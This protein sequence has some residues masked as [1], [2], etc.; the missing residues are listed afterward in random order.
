[1]LCLSYQEDIE[2]ST[3][4][5]SASSSTHVGSWRVLCSMS[6]LVAMLED[7]VEYPDT[8]KLQYGMEC[9]RVCRMSPDLCLSPGYAACHLSGRYTRIWGTS[10]R[11]YSTPY[12]IASCGAC[13]L[14]LCFSLLAQIHFPTTSL[15]LM[16]C[17]TH[18]GW[19]LCKALCRAVCIAKTLGAPQLE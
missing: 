18:P 3:A 19:R 14:L 11:F 9:C 12:H 8:S 10:G 6:T 2:H 5:A 4:G 17:N 15:G 7:K 13:M 1:M 16:G